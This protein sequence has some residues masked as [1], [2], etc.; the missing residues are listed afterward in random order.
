MRVCVMAGRR[1]LVVAFA[2]AAGLA[3]A[4]G[5]T[6]PEPRPY[7][8][9]QQGAEKP[10]GVVNGWKPGMHLADVPQTRDY[11]RIDR[12]IV[13]PAR[14]WWNRADVWNGYVYSPRRFRVCQ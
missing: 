7:A 12:D 4:R 10:P 3:G 6:A 13:P 11:L 1:T 2:L 14:C 5:E 9:G 8:R